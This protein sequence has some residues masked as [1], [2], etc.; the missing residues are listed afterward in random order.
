MMGEEGRDRTQTFEQPLVS[1]VYRQSQDIS[2]A[3]EMLTCFY[4]HKGYKETKYQ[5]INRM[6]REPHKD[7]LYKNKCIKLLFSLFLS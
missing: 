2:L 5:L 3:L 1:M 6:H 7:G 4:R